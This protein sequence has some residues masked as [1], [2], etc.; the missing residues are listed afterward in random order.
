MA[1]DKAKGK[2]KGKAKGKAEA[3]VR[4]PRANSASNT[5][6]ELLGEGLEPEI[7]VKQAQKKHPDRKI[8][9][10]LVNWLAQGGKASGKR[11]AA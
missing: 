2:G 10:G 5:I 6:R 3:K 11:A 8:T 9:M 7:I 4:T 1:K